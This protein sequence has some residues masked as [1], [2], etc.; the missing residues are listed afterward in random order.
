MNSANSD[1]SKPAIF[2]DTALAKAVP[3]PNRKRMRSP[4]PELVGDTLTHAACGTKEDVRRKRPRVS[5]DT[6][7]RSAEAHTARV[8]ALERRSEALKLRGDRPR[9]TQ[10]LIW[11]SDK[12]TIGPTALYSLTADPLPRPPLS[13]FNKVALKTISENPDLFKITC[14]IHV[15]V[16]ENLLVDHPKPLFCQSVLTGLREGFWP[17]PDKPEEYPE[18]H[19]NSD[20]PP[21]TDKERDFLTSQVKSEQMAGQLSAPFGPDLPAMY[22]PPVH[23]VPKPASEKLRMVVD[24]SA[25]KDSLNSMIDPKDIAGVKLDGI[26][27][28]GFS[29]RSFRTDNPNSKLVVFKS[30]VGAAY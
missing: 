28:L 9:Y 14:L 5:T 29:L 11:D 26:N 8:T 20:R 12:E 16:L 10:Q 18:T 17:W 30:D 21:K 3:N 25:G 27:S 15:D 1:T 7:A 23:A 22:S 6:S 13:A 19:D 2:M 24:H 4:E